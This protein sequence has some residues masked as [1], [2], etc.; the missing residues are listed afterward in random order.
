[1][2]PTEAMTSASETR[3]DGEQFV[4]VFVGGQMFGLPILQVRDVFM[5]SDITPVPLAP[6]TIAG[7]FNLRGRVV[8]MLSMQGMLGIGREFSVAE[9]TAIG[10]EWRGEAYGLLVESVGEV[11]HLPASAREANPMNLDARWAG[12]SAGVYRLK[13]RLLIELSFEALFNA[14]FARAA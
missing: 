14:E 13:D 2:N 7:L 6:R 4:T 1:M 8:T 5:V 11:M 9:R 12:L 3:D 10:V